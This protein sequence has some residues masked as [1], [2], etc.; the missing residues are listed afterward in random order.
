MHLVM[1]LF[2]LAVRFNIVLVAKHVPPGVE[3]GVADAMSRNDAASFSTQVPW[4]RRR[5]LAPEE[6]KR[7]LV[8]QTL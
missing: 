7:A 2:I 6:L 3:N 4:A 1:C 5:S 8:E